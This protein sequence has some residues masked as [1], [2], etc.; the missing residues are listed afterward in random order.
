MV[1]RTI[2]VARA[3]LIGLNADGVDI[4]KLDDSLREAAKTATAITI[5]AGY[6]NIEWL[7]GLCRNVPKKDR[8]KC[9]LRIAVGLDALGLLPRTWTDLRG[10][11]T[12]L[13]KMGFKKVTL[14]VVP[15]TP[16]H[17]HT[18]LFYFL[19][20]SRPIWFVGSANLGSTRHELMVNFFGR[21][22][23]L[24]RYVEAVFS[25]ATIVDSAK[26]PKMAISTL[27]DFFLTG[28]LIHRPPAARTFT[29][30]A[31]RFNSDDREQLVR[32]LSSNSGVAHARPT[33]SGFAF[34]LRSALG[35]DDGSNDDNGG[36]DIHEIQRTSSRT[37]SADTVFGHWVPRKYARTIGSQVAEAT[38]QRLARLTAFALALDAP[39][40][41]EL[42]KEQFAVHVADMKLFLT[43]NNIGAI[44]ISDQD[45]A[46]QRFLTSRHRLLVDPASRERQ[47][48]S[49]TIEQMPDIWNDDRAVT[50]F[51]A[52]FFEDLAYR[53]GLTGAGRGRIIK[54]LEGATGEYLPD[55]PEDLRELLEAHL[56]AHSWTEADWAE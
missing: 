4:A 29:F 24:S 46:F 55:S 18:K 19:K 25:V 26:P 48:R 45:G 34:S 36:V 30:D 21:H 16:V 35:L 53:A 10:A 41:L 11:G 44:P 37:Y 3:D 1:D 32:A 27:R 31:F 12:R 33:T 51:E 56:A 54:S 38:S 28:K 17:F 22:E 52:S 6:Y 5:L 15:S 49:I 40:G 8:P 13:S 43:E 42:A 20:T 47:A 14:A 23:A 9:T 7:L 39:G 2:H 50:A